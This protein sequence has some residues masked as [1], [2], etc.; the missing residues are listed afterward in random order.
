LPS[1]FTTPPAWTSQ[2]A[3]GRCGSRPR[4]YDASDLTATF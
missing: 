4:R 1:E 3:R 2:T